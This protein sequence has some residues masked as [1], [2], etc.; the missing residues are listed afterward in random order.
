M[1]TETEAT[2]INETQSD[3]TTT[4]NSGKP[5]GIGER[6]KL[7]R[8]AMHLSIK[9][10]GARLHLSPNLIQIIEAEDFKNSLPPTF[11]RGYI[12]S[13]GRLLNIPL[14][15]LDT[16]LENLSLN[17]TPT[18][19]PKLAKIPLDDDNERYIHWASYIII[20]ILVVLV[21]IW[22][23]SHPIKTENLFLKKQN[24]P[25]AASVQPTPAPAKTTPLTTTPSTI[26]NTPITA[27]PPINSSGKSGPEIAIPITPPAPSNNS[28]S[29]DPEKM[30]SS[31][32]KKAPL[33]KEVAL[34]MSLPEPDLDTNL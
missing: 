20:F 1:T 31:L 18:E 26:A 27:Q 24:M 14:S 10:A 5:T 3:P 29:Q 15:E 9:E 8:E 2:M 11:L 33:S 17:V 25:P 19:V 22:W 28:S 12:R 34:N 23:S 7:A 32:H 21:G 13:Y 16:A 4:L 6:F 30:S